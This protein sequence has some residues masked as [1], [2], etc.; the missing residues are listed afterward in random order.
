[1]KGVPN[2]PANLGRMSRLSTL[3]KM[4]LEELIDASSLSPPQWIVIGLCALVA[5]IDGF[6]TQS[7]GLA[8]PDIAAAWSVPVGQ[9][10]P[11]FSAGLFG[12]LLGATL[13]G[14]IADRLGRK[15]ALLIAVASF[16]LVTLA[17]PFCSSMPQLV[18]V[19]VLTGLGL[20]GA[21]PA[22]IS[23]TAEYAPRRLRA[24][25]VSLMFCGFPLGAVFGGLV[26]AKMLP[27]QGWTSIFYLGGAAPLVLLPV[28]ALLLPESARYLAHRKPE[29]LERLLKKWGWSDRWNG[30]SGTVLDHAPGSVRELFADGLGGRTILLWATLFCSLLL[31]YLLINWVPILARRAGI[32]TQ[33]AV[34]AVSTLNLGSIFGSLIIGRF[35]DRWGAMKMLGVAFLLGGLAVAC[36]GLNPGSAAQMIGIAFVAGFFSIGAQICTV[37]LS[38]TLYDTALRATGVGWAMAAGRTG[39]IVGPLIGGALLAGGLSPAALF[40]M[41]GAVSLLAAVTMGILSTIKPATAV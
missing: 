23:L 41:V 29:L 28:L 2:R 24:T 22:A 33:G 10:G 15:P 16:G 20:G 11:V 17:T 9:F 14:A 34:L 1:M 39:A 13:F 5:M 4:T 37:A 35:S 36:L 40:L 26:A 21:L 8:A 7:I 31:T 6:D 3:Q 19:R 12:G 25:L 32:G 27:A 18:A 30:E 38:P